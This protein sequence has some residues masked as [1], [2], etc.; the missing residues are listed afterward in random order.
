VFDMGIALGEAVI[1]NCPKLRWDFDPISAILPNEAKV[2]KQ[3]SGMSFQRPMLTGFDNPA[4]GKVPLHDVYMF[5]ISMMENT[6]TEGMKTFRELHRFDRRQIYEQLINFFTQALKD[7][8]EGDPVGLRREMGTEEYVK[9]VDSEA[10]KSNQDD[11][12]E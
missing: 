9:L 7:Y 6:T 3:S 4:Y 11:S 2:L 5:A 1:A 10:A 12:D 8:P